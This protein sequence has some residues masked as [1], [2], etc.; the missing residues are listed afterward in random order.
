ML[1]DNAAGVQQRCRASSHCSAREDTIVLQVDW[2]RYSE[3]FVR[4]EDEV[5]SMF[6]ELLIPK[7]C[8][9]RDT[10]VGCH[11]FPPGPRRGYFL[12][13]RDHPHWLVPNQIIVLGDRDTQV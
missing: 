13:Q 6:L 2:R 4:E 8:R 10:V 3:L 5:D 9:F 1:A 11:Y 12:N 7:Q